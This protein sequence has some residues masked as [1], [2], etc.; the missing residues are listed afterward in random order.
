MRF[1]PRIKVRTRLSL[2]F[3][4]VI[5]VSWGLNW[6]TTR[7]FFEKEF[8]RIRLEMSARGIPASRRDSRHE[9]REDAP[10]NDAQSRERA[11][12]RAL[13]RPNPWPRAI[14]VQAGI[15][16]VLSVVAGAWVSRRITRPLARL[17]EG[18]HAFH[19]RQ[20][21]HRIA[22]KG[23]DEFTRLASTMNEMAQRVEAQISALEDD[24]HR[25]QQLLADVAH[26]LRSPV[27]TLKTMAEALRDGV[28]NQPERR[29][30]ALQTMVAMA[31]R[32]QH[33]V[34]DLL[35]LAKLDL[36]ELP[37]HV[38]PVDLAAVARECVALHLEEAAR[39]G[40][41]IRTVRSEGRTT[42]K[43]DVVRLSQI[44]DNLLDNA[45]D[46]AGAGATVRVDVSGSD[47]VSVTVADTGRGISAEH[48]PFVFDPFY[49]VDAARTP[50]DPHSGL[51]LRIARG[52]AEAHGGT[53]DVE[54][55]EGE[56]TKATLILP[57][58]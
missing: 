52:L 4:L 54:S 20:F 42:V 25:R 53:L 37:L 6:V 57:A 30:R 29:E 9:D 58:A 44:L 32:M 50:G 49:R 38:A 34:T 12:L 19:E 10:P 48:L 22:E 43:G 17:E 56:G 26:E 5:V 33:L 16:L 28:A 11:R 31:D 46:Y 23:D 35:E 8:H 39:N 13:F 15:A 2:A 27:A 18:A 36:H 55:R 47:T 24:S 3:F 41:S 14:P 7:Y 45:I 40:V 21:Q 51:G 1:V